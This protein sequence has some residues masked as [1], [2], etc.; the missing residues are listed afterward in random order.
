MNYAQAV[1]DKANPR[2]FNLILAF[3]SPEKFKFVYWPIMPPHEEKHANA[4][5]YLFS[6]VDVGTSL[7]LTAWSVASS[8]GTTVTPVILP[9][10]QA[11]FSHTDILIIGDLRS[12]S[13]RSCWANVDPCG[14]SD[15]DKSMKNQPVQH[16]W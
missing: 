1:I 5:H 15:V 6:I 14:L 3:P 16:H 9:L 2:T 8:R 10:W 11:W 4:K 7:A 13:A 12:A